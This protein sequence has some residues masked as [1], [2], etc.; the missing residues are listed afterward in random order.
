MCP[1]LPLLGTNCR[2]CMQLKQIII[3]EHRQYY[4]QYLLDTWCLHEW[5]LRSQWSQKDG[6]S[7]PDG[8]KDPS[9]RMTPLDVDN[10]IGVLRACGTVQREEYLYEKYMKQWVII[11]TQSIGHCRAVVL[12]FCRSRK[13][14]LYVCTG[15]MPGLRPC[16]VSYPGGEYGGHMEDLGRAYAS[17]QPDKCAFL[18]KQFVPAR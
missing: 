7:M 4:L 9:S 1:P 2:I 10:F 16:W 3:W 14:S 11:L 18:M 5:S 8:L 17:P 15:A 6:A 13:G 12:A